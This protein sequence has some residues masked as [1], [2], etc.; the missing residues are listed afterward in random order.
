M[1]MESDK[2][3]EYKLDIDAKLNNSKLELVT[4]P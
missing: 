3:K 4:V 1:K 2:M